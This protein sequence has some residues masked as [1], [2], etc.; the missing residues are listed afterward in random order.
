MDSLISLLPDGVQDPLRKLMGYNTLL[1]IGGTRAGLGFAVY[2]LGAVTGNEAAKEFGATY[3]ILGMAMLLKVIN[4]IP[5]WILLIIMIII[6]ILFPIAA[7]VIY[8][9]C[10]AVVAVMLALKSAGRYMVNASIQTQL[11]LISELYKYDLLPSDAAATYESYLKGRPSDMPLGSDTSVNLGLTPDG[12]IALTELT[13][14]ARNALSQYVENVA[15]DVVLLPRVSPSPPFW[16]PTK[17]ALAALAGLIVL[18][19]ERRRYG[20][21][22]SNHHFSRYH[23]S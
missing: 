17:V 21:R 7:F 22:A 13:D 14:D 1:L 2:V 16:T 19:P 6:A 15:A 3:L 8:I 10:A 11:Y 4:A 9:I 12:A 23:N 5:K 20:F 18:S